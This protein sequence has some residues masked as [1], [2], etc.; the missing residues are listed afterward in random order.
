ML[1]MDAITAVQ[2][3]LHREGWT[4]D[5]L[6]RTPW[7][8]HR[9]GSAVPLEFDGSGFYTE[10]S[11]KRLLDGVRCYCVDG[12]PEGWEPPLADPVLEALRQVNIKL[13]AIAEWQKKMD[14]R[15]KE[16]R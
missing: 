1:S 4:V 15:L 16:W 11:F 8:R 10:A 5:V 12:P 7:A 2:E 9:C 3:I 13:D 6:S 14:K